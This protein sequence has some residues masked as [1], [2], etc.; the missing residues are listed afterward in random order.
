MS[1]IDEMSEIGEDPL[2]Q[3][4]RELTEQLPPITLQIRESNKRAAQARR[5]TL[6]HAAISVLV[7]ILLVGVVVL[8]VNQLATQK[9]FRDCIV[10]S[11]QCAQRNAKS[12]GEVVSSVALRTERER[13][14]TELTIAQQKGDTVRVDQMTAR[15]NDLNAKIAKVDADLAA[16]QQ[17][18]TVKSGN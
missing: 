6:W 11:G 1:E 4:V 14:N 17:Q 10:P 12:T 16:I 2:A 7:C 18:Q 5:L 9:Q 13:I 8:F 15:L 3:Q